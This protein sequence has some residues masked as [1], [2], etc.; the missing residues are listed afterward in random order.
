LFFFKENNSFK[1]KNNT[2][3]NRLIKQKKIDLNSRRLRL[4]KNVVRGS[5][6]DSCTWKNL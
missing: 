2:T 1:F 6:N 3:N 5:I 4:L